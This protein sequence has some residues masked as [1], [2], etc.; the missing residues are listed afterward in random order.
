MTLYGTMFIS[1]RKFYRPSP[2][3]QERKFFGLRSLWER[4]RDKQKNQAARISSLWPNVLETGWE[5]TETIYVWILLMF[6]TTRKTLGS[7]GPCMT[8]KF[9]KV[10]H[11]ER[12]LH[13]SELRWNQEHCNQGLRDRPPEPMNRYMSQPG[14][15][16]P[17]Q[18]WSARER[19]RLQISRKKGKQDFRGQNQTKHSTVDAAPTPQNQNTSP[20][21]GSI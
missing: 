18:R 8:G 3:H 14:S 6:D 20:T 13:R 16:E 19:L 1:L 10:K 15:V 9:Q 2:I 17:S 12:S 7:Y 4:I 11:T 5:Q 21:E